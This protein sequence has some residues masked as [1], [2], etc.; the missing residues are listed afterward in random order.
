M[1]LVPVSQQKQYQYLL[2][3]ALPSNLNYN[4]KEDMDS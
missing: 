3:N 4:F 1:A 2:E